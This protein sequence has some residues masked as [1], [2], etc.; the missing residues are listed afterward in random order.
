MRAALLVLLAFAGGLALGLH[1]R[2]APEPAR[3]PMRTTTPEPPLA[4]RSSL[5]GPEAK[6]ESLPEIPATAPVTI[7]RVGVGTLEFDGRL[8]GRELEAW[9]EHRT[10][11]GEEDDLDP[12][13]YD[14]GLQRWRLRAGI[15]RLWWCHGP[16]RDLRCVEVRIEPGKVTRVSASDPATPD[17]FPIERGLGRLEVVVFDLGGLRAPQA[18]FRVEYVDIRGEIDADHQN[19]ASDGSLQMDLLPGDYVVRV[20][21]QEQRVRV[22]AGQVSNMVFRSSTEGEVRLTRP[23][24]PELVALFETDS[25]THSW[26]LL[27]DGKSSRYIYVR[28]GR[29]EARASFAHEDQPRSLGFLDVAPG[30]ITGF[31]PRQLPT[32]QVGFHF[33]LPEGLAT[34]YADLEAMPL[35]PNGEP[36]RVRLRHEFGSISV[37][38]PGMT[39]VSPGRWRVRAT[40]AGCDP[41]ERVFEVGTNVMQLDIEFQRSTIR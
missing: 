38:S 18:A 3:R 22:V 30:V 27:P 40:A 2:E 5:P 13:E 14:D 1:L 6:A 41:L 35:D 25:R 7:E 37:H 9:V 36:R 34:R 19:A 8:D 10:I 39:H 20:G 11:E 17:Q 31:E 4:E 12:D 21:C 15:H 28:P 23:P 16:R 26:A 29:Y 32:A 24:F 33:V